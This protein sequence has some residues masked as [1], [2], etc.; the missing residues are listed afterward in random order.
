MV[1]WPSC[2]CSWGL[3]RRAAAEALARWRAAVAPAIPAVAG[4]DFDRDLDAAVVAWAVISSAWFLADAVAEEPEPPG[5]GQ[6]RG[7]TRRAVIRHRM[8]LVAERRTVSPPLAD[9]AEEVLTATADRW[10]DTR[11]DVAPAYRRAAP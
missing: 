4:D 6:G 11:L 3:P 7:P 5:G 2:W 9:L 10:G 1:P 8:G